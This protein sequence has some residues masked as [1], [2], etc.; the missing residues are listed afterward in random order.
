MNIFIYIIIFLLQIGIT[1]D[2]KC[3]FKS[4]ILYV[5]HHLLDV[6]TFW[7][8]LFLETKMEYQI[9]FLILIGLLMHWFTND[10]KCILTEWLNEDCGYPKNQWFNS[11]A[12]LLPLEKVFYYYHIVWILALLIYD[13]YKINN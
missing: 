8:P 13:I 1:L 5:G 11:L 6:F 7:G 9:H 12:N 3:L 4:P 2:E 10:Y